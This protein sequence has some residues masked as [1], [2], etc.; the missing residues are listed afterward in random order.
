MTKQNPIEPKKV[1][2]PEPKLIDVMREIKTLRADFGVLSQ[3]VKALGKDVIT[4]NERAETVYGDMVAKMSN[5]QDAFIKTL[6]VTN[7]SKVTKQP[8]NSHNVATKSQFDPADLMEHKGW[9]SK[10][11]PDGGY[12]DGS[13]SWG[14]DF[15][16][17]FKKETVEALRKG[18]VEID[19]YTFSLNKTGTL[20]S[21]MKAQK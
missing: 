17:K 21:T 12:Y 9:K 13:L 20:V 18:A 5:L 8:Q 16:D 2:V 11:R 1:K 7:V 10:K 15:V 3:A 6:N 4:K 19:Q 14:W